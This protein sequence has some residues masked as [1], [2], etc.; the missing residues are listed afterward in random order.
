M[1]QTFRSLECKLGINI[2]NH[3][4]IYAL[5]KGCG[6]RYTMDEID[7]A[8][9]AGCPYVPPG[10]NE[11]C[12]YPVKDEKE[13]YGGARKRVPLKSFPYFPVKAGIE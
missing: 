9:Q 2:N 8:P 10:T 7:N 13:L 5:C 1:A 12:R 6:T 4:R 3:L 11:P